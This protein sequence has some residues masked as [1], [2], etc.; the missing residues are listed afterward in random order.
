MLFGKRDADDGDRQ[1]ERGDQMGNGD[2]PAKKDDPQQIEN[3]PQRAVG[4]SSLH[5]FFAKRSKGGKAQFDRLYPKGYADNGQAERQTPDN[6]AQTGDET[7]E[8]QLDNVAKYTHLAPHECYFVIASA[9]MFGIMSTLYC[10]VA[11]S[12]KLRNG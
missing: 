10:Y 3:Q 11:S 2:L 7:A 12:Q 5:D 8:D 9:P 1:N 6:V 4:V